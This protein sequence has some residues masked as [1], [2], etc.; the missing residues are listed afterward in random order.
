MRIPAKVDYAIRALA[1]LA[2]AGDT[3]VKAEQLAEAQQIPLNFL[4]DILS[5]LRR[6]RLVRSHRGPDGGFVLGRPADAISLADIFR[7]VDGPLAEV[8]DQSLSAM[9]YGG[10]ARHGG[11]A[12]SGKD[13]SKVDRSGAYF[14]RLVAREVVKQG[15][16][17]RA[18]VQVAYAIGVARPISVLVNTFGTGDPRAAGEFVESFDFRPGAIAER[19]ELLQ[20]IYRTTTNYGH[21]GKTDPEITWEKADKTGDLKRALGLDSRTSAKAAKSTPRLATAA[22]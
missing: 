16:A 19:L 2:A 4:R 1:E 17:R 21:F 15:Y 20:P 11:G 7:A 12:F 5:D 18:E 8:R 22:A 10:A 14:C 9:T 13:P 6:T 3:Q